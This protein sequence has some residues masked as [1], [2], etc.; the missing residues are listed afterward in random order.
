MRSKAPKLPRSMPRSCTA[1]WAPRA[2]CCLSRPSISTRSTFTW[3]KPLW[4]RTRAPKPSRSCMPRSCTACW[5]PR[6][7]CCPCCPSRARGTYGAI[8]ARA[9][10]TWARAIW[11]RATHLRRHLYQQC[12]HSLLTL[13]LTL[14]PSPDPTRTHPKP[15]PRAKWVWA[16]STHPHRHDLPRLTHHRL[17]FN[18]RHL[19]RH[20]R[21][22]LHRLLHQHQES[23]YYS[24]S[25]AMKTP[26]TKL[27][28]R[29]RWRRNSEMACNRATSPSRLGPRQV[30]PANAS[31]YFCAIYTGVHAAV[32]DMP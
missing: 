29:S 2:C 1:C 5:E 8:W 30:F 32:V 6:M 22:L 7:C 20:P 31:D 9:R 12:P 19:H 18:L 17:I 10:A 4:A 21:R 11:A 3:S 27:V 13:T 16:R 24:P 15:H 28:S 25:K 26:S 14:S 23:K